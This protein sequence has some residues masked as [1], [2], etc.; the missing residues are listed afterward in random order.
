[1]TEPVLPVDDPTWWQDPYPSLAAA[2]DGH[3]HARTPDGVRVLL[4]FAD[5]ETMKTSGAVE[6]EGLEYIEDRGFRPGDPLYEWRRHSIG[7]RNGDDHQRLRRLVN[8]AMTFRSVDRMRG[9]AR[10]HVERA[11]S[12]G[13]EPG[14]VVELDARAAF[15]PL[16]FL[17]I[18]D[19][20]GIDPEAATEMAM[21][22]GRGSADAFGPQVTPE[23]RDA[24]NQTFAVLM[25][26]VR[27]LVDERRRAP[28]DDLLTALIEAEEDGDRLSED[29]LIVLFTNI[30][31]GAIESTLSAMT[32]TV[33]EF[34]NHP[35]QREMLANDPDGG[36]RA[37]VEEVIRHRPS[38][39]A[40]GG[41]ASR[42]TRIGDVDL[43][44]DERVSIIVGGP[45]RD[46]TRW[47]DPEVFDITRDPT[48]WSFSFSMG[49][50]FCLG[51]ALA[52]TELQETAAAVASRCLDLELTAPPEWVP[53]VSVN[54]V[55]T[56][57]VRYRLAEG[58]NR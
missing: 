54:R 1:M 5:A 17:V 16:P 25:D 53:F 39:Y 27:G 44:A 24:A 35:E 3:G 8:R 15:R 10:S 46:P 20:L 42:A 28:K 43:T 34:A 13:A 51:Q 23:I 14:D 41:R 37:A 2:R 50:H 48:T 33:L 32:S 52:R 6:N 12:A 11:L 4:R 55:E 30:F 22:M 45:N 26:F 58:H 21:T 47:T 31:G 56:L 57:P 29:E 40:I 9:V 7:A 36:K 19:F 18:T 49:A 38:F